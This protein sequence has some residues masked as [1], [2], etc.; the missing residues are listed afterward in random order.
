MRGVGDER[1]PSSNNAIQINDGHTH[2]SSPNA[3]ICLM[4]TVGDGAWREQGDYMSWLLML[5]RYIWILAFYFIFQQVSI[6]IISCTEVELCD[7]VHPINESISFL[8]AL[9]SDALHSCCYSWKRGSL[10]APITEIREVCLTNVID[11]DQQF[12][13]NPA[14]TIEEKV[15]FEHNIP[16]NRI[17]H[18]N[19]IDTIS[20][21]LIVM[22]QFDAA[23]TRQT[24]DATCS[25]CNH[26][27]P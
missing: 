7:T 12:V 18:D 23:Q 16:M 5:L 2:L 25:F 8:R 4:V 1:L 10:S 13:A 15:S 26:I 21:P 11:R 3:N 24:R 27:H 17:R 22:K 14:Y 20:K 6:Q 19:M 9:A